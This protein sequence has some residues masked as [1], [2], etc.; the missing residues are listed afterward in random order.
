MVFTY[1]SQEFCKSDVVKAVQWFFAHGSIPKGGNYSFITLIP[2]IPNANMVKDFRPINLIGSMYKIV[3]KILA[4]RLVTVLGDLVNE[5][6]SAFVANRQI[7][8][9]PFILNEVFQW[10]KNRKKNKLWCLKLILKKLMT[11]LDGILLMM[12]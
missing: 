6:Q 9:G 3:A 1:L 12:F 5:T 2:K 11:R 7:L 10:C 8:D 4:N